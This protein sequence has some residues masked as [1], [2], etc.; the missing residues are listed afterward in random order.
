MKDRKTKLTIG[1]GAAVFGAI[2]AAMFLHQSDSV[3]TA[4]I[5]LL[6]SVF[7][8]FIVGNGAEHISKALDK[9]APKDETGYEK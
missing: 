8:S 4:L 7:A 9:K 6:G 1:F 3:I 5:T 2:F